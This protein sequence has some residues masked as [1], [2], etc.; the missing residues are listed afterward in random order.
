MEIKITV[1]ILGFILMAYLLKQYMLL[2]KCIQA[3]IHL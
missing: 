2:K 3:D 1:T